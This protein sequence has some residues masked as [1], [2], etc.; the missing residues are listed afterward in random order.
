VPDAGVHPV[1]G[2]HLVVENPGIE[3]FL[4]TEPFPPSWASYFP[5]GDRVVLGGVA[6]DGD[7]ALE[8]REA[9]AELILDNCAR[10]EP[11]LRDARVIEHM[12]GLRPARDDVRVEAERIGSALCVHN[13]GHGGAGV[14]LSW[15]C[16]RE[17]VELVAKNVS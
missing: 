13:Y 4:I 7:W 12:V 14:A 5:H 9:D 16:A 6:Q 11:R 10:W 3:E 15:G 8:P 17:V 1:R 2:Q